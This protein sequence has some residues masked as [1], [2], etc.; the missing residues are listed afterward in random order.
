MSWLALI[1]KPSLP[2]WQMVAPLVISGLGMS[3]TIP[4]AQSAVMTHVAPQHIGKASGTFTTVRQLGGALGIAIAVAV[5]A[6]AGS[7]QS[8]QAFSDGFGPALGVCAALALVAAL[9]GLLAPGRPTA[10][11]ADAARAVADA[12]LV[13]LS[14]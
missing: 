1:A 3:M 2:Y 9:V 14:I 8:P 6:A 12:E 4:A 10:S 13:E 7:Y 5:F 11:P